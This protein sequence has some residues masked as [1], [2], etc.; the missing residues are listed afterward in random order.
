M[1]NLIF[2]ILAMLICILPIKANGLDFEAKTFEYQD[3]SMPY[4]E[5]VV[6][7]ESDSTA[8][9]VILLHARHGCGRNNDAHK[10]ADGVDEIG[11]YLSENGIKAIFIVPQVPD[12]REWNESVAYQGFY[13]SDALKALIDTYI[14]DDK[15]DAT[16]IYVLGASMGGSGVWRLVNDYPHLFAGAMA[17]SAKA[18]D[19][20]LK[21]VL[22][23]PILSVVGSRDRLVKASSMESTINKINKNGGTAKFVLL[24]GYSHGEACR[25]AF[26]SDN[27][28]WV[29]SHI[30]Q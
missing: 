8:S 23:T 1:K 10:K 9:L 5:A 24:D 4:R 18:R 26:T 15:I 7:A 12:G 16:K 22:D 17:A 28:Q 6:N 29:F 30:N 14:A 19:I 11:K 25:G 21:N 2:T 13:M 20:K 27:L 3:Y